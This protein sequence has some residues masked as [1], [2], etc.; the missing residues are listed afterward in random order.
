MENKLKYIPKNQVTN[1]TPRDDTTPRDNIFSSTP[2]ISA[3]EPNEL[4]E[5]DPFLRSPGAGGSI[6][7]ILILLILL[8]F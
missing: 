2:N 7:I 6:I 4:F 8:F 5:L 1:H 3:I